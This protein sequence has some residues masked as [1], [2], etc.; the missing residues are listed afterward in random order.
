MTKSTRSLV[1]LACLTAILVIPVAFVLWPAGYSS[2]REEAR[3]WVS[4]MSKDGFTQVVSTIEEYPVT[5][6]KEILRVLTPAQRVELFRSRLVN[7]R[8][9]HSL[10]SE[11]VEA[12]HSAEAV[13]SEDL[14]SGHATPAQLEALK[15][16]TKRLQQHLGKRVAASLVMLGPPD[17]EL[18][19]KNTP[20][21]VQLIRQKLVVNA[22]SIQCSCSTES[23]WCQQLEGGP[24]SYC[25]GW[26]QCD[27]VTSWPMCGTF[28]MYTCNG[29]CDQ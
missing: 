2:P 29:M 9:N 23:D 5:Y 3:R 7:Y 8:M 11:A 16:I 26:I 12:L 6:R 17:A 25:N 28:Y 27:A 4:T 24:L 18:S 1:W 13:L 14:L 19:P 20:S 22:R 21:L 10:P 15:P